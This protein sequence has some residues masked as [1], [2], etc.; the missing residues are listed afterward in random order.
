MS[1]ANQPATRIVHADLDDL[2][3]L[4]QVTATAFYELPPSRWLVPDPDVRRQILPGYFRLVVEHAIAH[5]IVYTTEDR[6]A[7]AGWLPAG[8][9]PPAPPVAPDELLS[10]VTDPWTSRFLAFDAALAQHHPAIGAHHHHLAMIGV[11]PDRQGQGLGTALL[12]AHHDLLDRTG[13]PAYLEAASLSTRG[14]YLRRG[15]AD[16]GA[17]PMRLPD[18]TPMYPMVRDPVET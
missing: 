15:Y 13:L 7:V 4:S 5:G 17:R 8:Q 12:Q 11:R 6:A 16:H 18:G 10:A 14:V 9:Q 3:I 2:D 1:H